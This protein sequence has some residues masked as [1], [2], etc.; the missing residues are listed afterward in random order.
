MSSISRTLI[1]FLLLLLAGACRAGGGSYEAE[2]P[3]ELTNSPDLCAHAPCKDVLPGAATFSPRMGR[4][5]YVEGYAADGREAVGYVFLSTDIVDIPGY[6]GKPVVTLIGMDAKG[7]ITG[8]KILKHSEPILLVGIPESELTKFCAQYIGRFV[9]SRIEVGKASSDE[10]TLGVDAISGATVTVIAEN[11]LILRSG[12]EVAKQVGIV[13]VRPRPAAKFVAAAAPLSWEALLEEG[14]VQHIAV[15]QTQVGAEENGEPYIDLYF[16]YL[17]APGVGVSVLGQDNYDRLLADLKPGEHAIFIV[18][19]GTGSFK[20]SGFV[21]GGIYDRIQVAQEV[22]SFTFRDTDY[23]NLYS[24]AAE[25][26][27]EFHEAGIFILRSAGFTAAFPWQLQLLA[28]KVDEATG[29]R[30]FVNFQQRYWLADRYFDGGR[31]AYHAPDPTWMRVWKAKRLEIAG[32][33][34]F[35]GVLAATYGQ[36]ERLA[37]RATHKDKRWVMWPKYFFWTVSVFYIG[38]HAMAQPSVTQVLTWFHALVY[39]WRWELFLSDP[40]IFILWWFMFLTLL[41][42]GRGLFCGW[43]CPYGALTELIYRSAGRL[44]LQRFQFLLPGRVH[45]RL[46]WVKYAVF[47]G[48]LGVSFYSM[49]LAERLAEVEPFKTTFLVGVFHRSWPFATFWAVLAFASAFTE[50]P[51]CKYLC[52][53]GAGLAIPS[54][55]RLFGLKRKAECTSCAACAK[56][57]GSLAIDTTGRIDQRECLLCLDC[58]VLYFDQSAC[59]PLVKE[60]KA[61]EKAGLPLTAIGDDGYLLPLDGMKQ[62]L[63]AARMKPRPRA[64]TPT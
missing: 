61:R 55:F 34:L 2:L 12:Y 30:A 6:S 48:L 54:T 41:W 58:T 8:V 47:A 52:P 53:L 22:D 60:R 7:L 40:F 23:Q 25:G 24:V 33:L 56:G 17:N 57:C 51:F 38:F 35:L 39:E 42:W 28:N 43:L 11:Q 49:P 14:S 44:G 4:P 13:A 50:R 20:G 15:T 31:P 18:A 10:D 29:A 36:R 27:P 63:A 16:G 5:S 1:G 59:P 32:L 3:P 21:R 62:A 26:A 64:V 46:K 45:D 9:G 19:N 37:R